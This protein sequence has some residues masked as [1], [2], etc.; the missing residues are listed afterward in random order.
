MSKPKRS[1]DGKVLFYEKSHTYKLGKKKLTSGTTFVK[2]FVNPFDAKDIARK[3]SKGF[4]F[5]NNRKRL[6]G[7]EVTDLEK[8]KQTMKHWI[9]EWKQSAIDGTSVHYFMEQLIKRENKS[10]H[11]LGELKDAKDVVQNKYL[12]GEEWFRHY[13]RSVGEPSMFPEVITYNE[14]AGIA[15]Q[16]D[17]MCYR[18]EIVN[19]VETINQVLDIIDFKTNKSIDKVS[20]YGNKCLTPLEEF[21]DC[22]FFHYTLQLSLYAFMEEIKG[23]PIGDLL[24]IHLQEDK[25]TVIKVPYQRDIIR[26]LLNYNEE[27]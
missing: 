17:L 21:S 4:K 27:K 19:G 15:G 9:N 11:K 23:V 24:L 13:S 8:K 26:T 10:D 1:P 5:R 3:I 12:Q 18:N 22:N 25:Y 20:K 6:Q 2:Q 16:I 14:E 7:L